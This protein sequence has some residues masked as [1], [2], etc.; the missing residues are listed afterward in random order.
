M[1]AIINFSVNTFIKSIFFI[2]VYGHEN[3]PQNGPV[4][5]CANHTSNFDP[6]V[7]RTQVKREINFLAKKELFQNKLLAFILNR[8]SVI[9][10]DRDKNDLTAYKNVMHKLKNKEVIGIFLQGTR[11][12]ENDLERAKNGAAMFAIKSN[13]PVIPIAIKSDFKLFSQV[14][15]NI[16]QPINFNNSNTKKLNHEILNQ[17]T[18]KITN[19]IKFLLEQNQ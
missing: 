1:K 3:I 2:K 6:L 10:V 18:T 17:A 14:I 4:V 12:K 15:I 5:L 11:N 19:Q 13:A 7:L 9:A 16:G 8:F